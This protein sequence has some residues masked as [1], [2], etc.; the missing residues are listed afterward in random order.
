MLRELCDSKNLCHFDADFSL[1]DLRDYKS[2]RRS[3]EGM[4]GIIHLGAR[5]TFESYDILRPSILNGSIT[6][7]EA[8][9]AL[10]ACVEQ[11]F[12]GITPIGA[13]MQ[14]AAC[15]HRP[16]CHPIPTSIS[17]FLIFFDTTAVF[18]YSVRSYFGHN[19]QRTCRPESCSAQFQRQQ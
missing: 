8:T 17:A 6:L 10:I 7:M 2:L 14:T 15:R 5:A 3:V 16:E 11:E 12:S 18:F 19:Q 1:G 13:R 9:A 4:D